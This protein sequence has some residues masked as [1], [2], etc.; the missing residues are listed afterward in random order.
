MPRKF[1]LQIGWL[2]E[3]SLLAACPLLGSFVTELSTYVQRHI[4]HGSV[5]HL[6]IHALVSRANG[7]Y[8]SFEVLTGP[9]F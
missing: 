6:S 9:D 1:Y 2:L 8:F 4:L 3:N 5:E 7:E